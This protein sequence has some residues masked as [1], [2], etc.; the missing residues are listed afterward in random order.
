MAQQNKE[1][2]TLKLTLVVTRQCN[3]DCRYCLQKHEDAVMPEEM[4]KKAIDDLAGSV[5]FQ[6]E[7]LKKASPGETPKVRGQISF[8][9]GEPLLQRPLI[10]KL[11]KYAKAKFAEIE[12]SRLVFEITTNGTLLDE[13]FVSF[14]KENRIILALSHDGLSQDLVRLDRGGHPTK[15]LVDKK[16]DMLLQTFPDTIIMMTVHPDH[17]DKVAESLE[18]FRGKGVRAVSMVL[19]HGERV[20]WTDEKFEALSLEMEKVEKLY[21]EWNLG[22][23][24]FRFIPFENKIR[25]YI[26]GK[27]ADSAPCHFGC[28]KLMVDTDGKYYPCSHFIR[29]E[30]FSVGSIDEGLDDSRLE[31]LESQRIEPK[32]CAECALSSRCHHTCACANHGHTG[33]MSEVS[34][35]QCEYEKLLIR[36]SDQ[37]A[38]FLMQSESP[39]FIERMYRN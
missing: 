21:E 12:N 28:H 15:A 22:D 33:S 9:G 34:A 6:S 14:A 8:Y 16:L 11:V 20:L 10:E 38:S 4:G 2:Q 27:D 25:N 24:I 1:N 19:A 39:G 29:L 35:L 5:L 32:D 26:R 37:A 13:A 36:L 7:K 23:S 3:F 30:G 17:V 31:S 18:F